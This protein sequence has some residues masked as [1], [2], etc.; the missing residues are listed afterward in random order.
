MEK[1]KLDCGEPLTESKLEVVSIPL[2]NDRIEGS[3]V[4]AKKAVD[5]PASHAVVETYMLTRD[6]V[7]RAGQDELRPG[8]R[9]EL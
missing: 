2:R 3:G 7:K 6:V 9:V 4:V 8:G 1:G 5:V